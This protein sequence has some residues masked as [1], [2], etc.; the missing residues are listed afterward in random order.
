MYLGRYQQGQTIVFLLQ[1][2]NED[3][4][5]TLPEI[6]PQIKIWNPSGTLIAT[7]QMP[8][9]DRYAFTGLFYHRLFLSHGYTVTGGWQATYLYNTS[10]GHYGFQADNF[11][12]LP[13]GDPDGHVVG[14][15]HYRRPHADFLVHQTE[16]GSIK[17]GRNP[18]V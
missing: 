10:S 2:V 5:A 16:S 6:P 4:T 11:E 15:Y 12:L 14:M 18:R 7:S 3:G 9:L 1:C 8:I 17:K 13:G